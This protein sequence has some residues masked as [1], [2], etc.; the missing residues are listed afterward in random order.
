[1]NQFIKIPRKFFEL[2]EKTKFID[3]LIY[4]IIDNQKCEGKSSIAYE[5]ISKKYNIPHKSIEDSIKRLVNNGF[6]TYTQLP[7][8]NYKD[9]LY[10]V[11]EFPLEDTNYL[12]LKPELIALP[13]K[14]KE[15][16]FLIYLQLC[17][18][19]GLNQIVE[20]TYKEIA[21]KL[22]VKDD[23]VSK[24]IKF[25]IKNNEITISKAGYYTCKYL[26]KEEI[27]QTNKQLL[28]L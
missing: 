28:I 15:R 20:R 8:M 17:C 5:T 3:V 9:R 18:M 16:G 26:Q 23:T 6:L 22:N 19:Y 21:A 12:M 2:K 10:N 13:Y 7:S 1:M 11:Y 27:S 24:Y 4:A 14:P 25:F